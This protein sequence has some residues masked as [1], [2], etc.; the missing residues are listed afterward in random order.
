MFALV[1]LSRTQEAENAFVICV[2]NKPQN[3]TMII[4]YCPIF[5]ACNNVYSDLKNNLKFEITSIFPRGN[6]VRQTDRQRNSAVCLIL[7]EIP[8]RYIDFDWLSFSCYGQ[9]RQKFLTF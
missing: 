8:C 1:L 2:I 4:E 5:F 6:S 3:L 9:C 7:M